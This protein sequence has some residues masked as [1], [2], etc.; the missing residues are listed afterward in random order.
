MLSR[1]SIAALMLF[2][3]LLSLVAHATEE[4]EPGDE[5]IANLI[6]RS[7]TCIYYPHFDSNTP[8]EMFNKQELIT[9]ADHTKQLNI[10][11][12]DALGRGNSVCGAYFSQMFGLEQNLDLLR[13]HVLEPGRFYGWEGLY[14]GSDDPYLSDE[15]YVYDSKY[16]PAIE[17]LAGKNIRDFMNLSKLEKDKLRSIANDP[18]HES[19]EWAVWLGKKL[20]VL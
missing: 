3:L 14:Q 17:S 2:G 1:Q 4:S 19:H 5:N 8:S 18:D 10:M 15:Q 13:Y 7:A 20:D 12:R 9:L 16:I 6:A 11:I